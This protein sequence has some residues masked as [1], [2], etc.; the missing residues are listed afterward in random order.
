LTDGDGPTR[1][2]FRTTT[3]EEQQQE[4]IKKNV[5]PNN[6]RDAMH[7]QK[8]KGAMNEQSSHSSDIMVNLIVLGP[9]KGGAKGIFLY[10]RWVIFYKVST[11]LVRPSGGMTKKFNFYSPCH[12]DV[13][14]KKQI[15]TIQGIKIFPKTLPN[16]TSAFGRF[17]GWMVQV[18]WREGRGKVQKPNWTGR[19]FYS[20]CD[21]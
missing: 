9:A 15:C 17:C 16:Y 20:P 2:I 8:L 3:K 4:N 19:I 21:L 13:S 5:K 18:G 14:K 12:R 11:L 1:T 7:L 10:S 6:Q